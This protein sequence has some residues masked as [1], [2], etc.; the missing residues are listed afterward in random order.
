M[1]RPRELQGRAARGRARAS[2]SARRILPIVW[3]LLALATPGAAQDPHGA[4]GG[5]PTD[6]PAGDGSLEV[7]VVHPSAPERAAGLDVA[8]YALAPDGTPGLRSGRTG[9]DGVVRFE[10]I[11]AASDVV[12]LV[13]ARYRDIPFGRRAAFAPGQRALE[14]EIE[15]NDPIADTGGIRVV[16]SEWRLQWLGAELWVHETHTLDNGSERVVQVPEAD[17][18]GSAPAF[19]GALPEGA[20]GFT[21]AIGSFSQGLDLSGSDLRFWGPVYPGTQEVRYQYRLPVAGSAE[22]ET[23]SV[24]AAWPSGADRLL[25]WL[26]EAGPELEAVGRDLE[27]RDPVDRDGE[28][29]RVLDAGA[30]EAGDHLELAI[31]IPPGSHDPSRLGIARADVWVDLDDVAAVV[32]Q[33][34]RLAVTDGNRLVG[35]PQEPLLRFDLPPGAQLLGAS[36]NANRLGLG[37]ADGVAAP[38]LDLIGPLPPGETSFGFRYRLPVADPDAPLVLPLGW[39]REVAVANVLIADTGLIVEDERLHRMRPVRSGTRTYIH[40]EGFQIG[41]DESLSIRIARIA[42]PAAPLW[43]SLGS[44]LVLG[45]LGAAFVLA[46]LRSRGPESAASADPDDSAVAREREGVVDSLR[47]LEHDH[48]TGKISDADYDGLRAQLRGRALELMR[49]ER[50]GATAAPAPAG[51]EAGLRP[52]AAPARFCPACGTAAEEGW[53]FCAGCGAALP[54]RSASASPPDAAAADAGAPGDA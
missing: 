3:A 25:L 28:T 53:R 7:R 41:A 1:S 42:R 34:V 45:L 4:V 33:E 30:L 21:P 8:L 24:R 50:G 11:S 47:D 5:A 49:L 38:A 16:E 23:L 31:R 19:R 52:A 44:T 32:S 54:T 20:S 18:A 10:G 17:R 14:V 37:A 9:D 22:E 27:A 15:V 29:Y 36:Q 35:S 13:G 2:R 39:P 26:P 46:P 48:E 51:S 40:R 6:V 43:A 12:Y